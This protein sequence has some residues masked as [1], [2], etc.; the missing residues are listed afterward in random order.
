MAIVEMAEDNVPFVR[1]GKHILRLN[2]EE[3]DDEL[4][5]RS[6]K[7]LRETPEIVQ[8]SMATLRRLLAGI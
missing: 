7:E 6:R 3:L 8:E 5:E 4:K 1:L 2:L